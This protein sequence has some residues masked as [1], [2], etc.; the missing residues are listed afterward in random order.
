MQGKSDVFQTIQCGKQI[1]ELENEAN[2]V[3]A[4]ARE[5]V[6]GKRS[7]ILTVNGDGSAAGPIQSAN[8]IQERGL[9]GTGRADNRDK[10]AVIDLKIHVI[11]RARLSFSFE[12]LGYTGQLDHRRSECGANSFG[13]CIQ[14]RFGGL[15]AVT[16][17]EMQAETVSRETRKH[18]Q[19]NME[20][21]L[22]RDFS[23]REK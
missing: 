18:V 1:E 13:K 15:F 21:F 16:C 8:Q 3:A 2:L 7:Q 9:S 23:I 19:V 20:D 6:V 4:N 5:V 11:Q 14:V 12:Y 10:I 17:A 22:A